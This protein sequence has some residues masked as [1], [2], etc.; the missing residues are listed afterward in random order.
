MFKVGLG[1]MAFNRN[2]RVKRGQWA[3]GDGWD[4]SS[5]LV[6]GWKVLQRST[7]HP[8]SINVITGKRSIERISQTGQEG[9]AMGV[10]SH[11]VVSDFL[12]KKWVSWVSLCTDL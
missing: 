3:E 4:V 5:A 8:K 11:S 2:L 6:L 1:N 9:V 7:S 12:P 10:Y